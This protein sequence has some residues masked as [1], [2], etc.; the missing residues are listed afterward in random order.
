V[1]DQFVGSSAAVGPGLGS[2]TDGTVPVWIEFTNR[3]YADATGNNPPPIDQNTNFGD[4]GNPVVAIMAGDD[5]FEGPIEDFSLSDT[6]ALSQ[7]QSPPDLVGETKVT[8]TLAPLRAGNT[9]LVRGS[10]Q[11]HSLS[12]SV[13]CLPSIPSQDPVVVGCQG[14]YRKTSSDSSSCPGVRQCITVGAPT[15][16]T[17]AFAC[18][19]VHSLSE[20]AANPDLRGDPR[21]ITIPITPVGH[22]FDAGEQHAV[23]DFAAFYVTG[24]DGGSG[25]ADNMPKPDPETTFGGG[26]GA[27]W[28]Y[29]VKFVL[30]SAS[31]TPDAESCHPQTNDQG[32][33]ACIATLVQ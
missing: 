18:T 33:S 28:G 22:A 1:G 10:V 24:W 4:A 9:V 21:L 16:G 31:G 19:P 11:D 5:R 30:S 15:N 17:P 14:A 2:G 20:L 25:C 23:V 26:G 8:L 13:D 7:S 3:G 6:T 12:G 27:I 29:F 32:I